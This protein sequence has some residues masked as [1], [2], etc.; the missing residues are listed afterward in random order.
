METPTPETLYR[1]RHLM[2]EHRARTARIL[3]DSV[4]YF[5]SPAS[6][7]DPFDCKVHFRLTTSEDEL[8]RKQQ[9]L[10][11]K[12][13]PDLNRAQRR[14]KAAQDLRTFDREKFLESMTAGFQG[15]VNKVGVLSLSEFPDEVLLWS[16]YAASHTGL[17]LGFSV[18]TDMAFFAPAQCVTYSADYPEI[19]MLRDDPMKHVEAFLLTKA[20][21]W[22]YENEWRIIDH[23]TGPGEKAFLAKA[24]LKVILGAR[25]SSD[26]KRFVAECLNGRKDAVSVLEASVKPGSYALDF[27]PYEP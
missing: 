2:G 18:A 3:T 25:M 15:E 22:K 13:A 26:D 16:H 24:L 12:Y 5:A 1:Y 8:R 11:K 20:A 7:N 19:D 10:L 6:F 14:T 4:L 21:G 23:S 27:R 17:C 9:S